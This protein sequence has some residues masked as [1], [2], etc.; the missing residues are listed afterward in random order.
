MPVLQGVRFK[1]ADGSILMFEPVK[2]T[3]GQ[4]TGRSVIYG[5]V[6]IPI[7]NIGE[8]QIGDIQHD[9]FAPLFADWVVRPSKEP[10]FGK[11]P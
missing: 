5:D 11:A 4:V 1:L 3:N 7:V 10:Q 6:S 8:L 9:G 2:A